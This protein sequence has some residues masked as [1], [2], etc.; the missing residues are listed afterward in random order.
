M[1]GTFTVTVGNK[2]RIVVPAEVRER[3]SWREGTPLVG[4]ETAAGLVLVGRD[5]ARRLLRDQLAG[6]DLV[7]DLIATRRAEAVHDAA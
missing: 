4:I 7:A 5:D 2:G 6:H 1:S 3:R